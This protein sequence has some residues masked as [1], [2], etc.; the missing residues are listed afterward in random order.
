MGLSDRLSDR[1]SHRTP[2]RHSTD[3]TPAEPEENPTAAAPDA[4]VPVRQRQ[5]SFERYHASARSVGDPIAEVRKRIHRSL[6][7]IL[8]PKL[9][10]ESGSDEDLARRVRET[11][12]SL[13]SRDETPMAGTDKARIAREVAD[14][15]LGH[16]PL[17][18]LLRDPAVSENKG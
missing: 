10:E 1:Y 2:G 12:N 7:E 15:I 16:G 6:L 8:G 13:L 9:Y 4:A 17:E 3:P 5:A 11:V 14:E 18:P